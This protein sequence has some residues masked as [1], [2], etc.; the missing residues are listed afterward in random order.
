MTDRI[1]ELEHALQ[2][3]QKSTGGASGSHPLLRPSVVKDDD[4]EQL[5]LQTLF[6][7]EAEGISDAIG[8][9]SIGID[10]QAKY[11]G[12]S[13][14]SEYFQELLPPEQNERRMLQDAKNLGLPYEIVDLCNAF[15]F[16]L[17]DCPYTKHQ[18]V[19]FLPTR[20]RALELAELYYDNVAWMYDPIVRNDFMTTIM[21]PI[22]GNTGIVNVDS[23]HSHRISVFFMLLASGILYDNHPSAAVIA[24]QYRALA[25]AS[26]GLDSVLQEATCA[27]VQALL[28]IVRYIYISDRTNN[29]T[30]WLLVGMCSRVAQII[31]LQRD[32]AGWN[33]GHEE[34]QRRRV[35]FWEIYTFDAWTSVVNGRP[36]SLSINHTDCRF[37]DDLDPTLKPSGNVEMGWH[38]WKFRYSAFCLSISVQHVFSARVP[39]YSTV[40]E[41][42]RNI[43][44]FP[45]PNHL[46]SP[47][48]VS[49][50]GRA[51]SSER[52]RA[53]QQYCALCVR[54]S[55]LLYIHRSYFAQATR[56]ASNNPLTHKYAPSV[57]AAYRSACRLISSLRGLYAVHPLATSLQW[58]FWS[59]IYSSCILLGA[60]VVESPRCS[61]ARNALQ[62]LD[63]ALIFY[64]EG[65]VN[66]RPPATITMLQ[67]LRQRAFATFTAAQTGI[68]DR[69]SP[70]SSN[71][72]AP[73]ELEVLGG[74]KS[75][76]T[77][78]SPSSSPASHATSSPHCGTY[79]TLRH[80]SDDFIK[81]FGSANPSLMEYYGALGNPGL[82]LPAT[83]D[84]D[85]P[86]VGDQT[87][88]EYS[89]SPLSGSEDYN[90]PSQSFDLGQHIDSMTYGD[91][92]RTQPTYQQSGRS[93]T[94]QPRQPDLQRHAQSENIP[95]REYNQ[96]EIWRD[97]ISHLG[98]SRP[99]Q[100]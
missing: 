100:S 41:L 77:N 7:Q 81:Q 48:Q 49:E 62:E 61:L 3:A 75:I 32:S 12:E 43:R 25:L 98:M 66:C 51:W 74:R 19:S 72:S 50:A 40:L 60:L 87:S 5:N 88:G 92:Q 53:M 27:T 70:T 86:Y 39:S 79:H 29:E 36:P 67:K 68:L 91:N 89:L 1:K 4:G 2:E 35:L 54:E 94:I 78:K 6:D 10:G 11:H 44:K 14:G 21:V 64:D 15:P 83:K 37:P 99:N 84:F 17:R 96:E 55:N 38:A 20:E 16:G 69:S 85:M 90:T 8:S 22:Y 95:T 13:A 26:F 80:A 42:D 59:G 46:Q 18:F 47:M 97:F 73:D 71:P 93:E 9:L 31:G 52:T 65:S 45:L 76:I 23:V 30:R 28:M 24:E 58:F 33:L 82:V 57:L 56:E 34:I 63:Q